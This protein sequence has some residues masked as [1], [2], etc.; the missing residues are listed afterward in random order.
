LR[1]LCEKKEKK[2]IR[3]KH[4]T[5]TANKQTNQ[6]GGRSAEETFRIIKSDDTRNFAFGSL[7]VSNN[8]TLL[9]FGDGD[10]LQGRDKAMER[11]V[12]EKARRSA[13]KGEERKGRD[14]P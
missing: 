8:K 5:T 6:A 1:Q 2:K 4:Q 10:L 3:S 9:R 12:V 7:V 13:E 14:R 11:R